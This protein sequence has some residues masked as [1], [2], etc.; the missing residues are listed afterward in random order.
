M[1]HAMIEKRKKN[2]DTRVNS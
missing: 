1:N 2:N